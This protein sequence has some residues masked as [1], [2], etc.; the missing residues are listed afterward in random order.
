MRLDE[1]ERSSADVTERPLYQPRAVVE[2]EAA[3]KQTS[4]W[5]CRPSRLLAV[6]IAIIAITAGGALWWL[7]ARQWESTDDAFID[8]HMVRIAPQVGGRVARVLVDDNQEVAAGQLMVEI[9]PA[10]FQAKLDQATANHAAAAGSL[11]QAKAQRAAAVANAEEA[12]AEVGVAEANAANATSQ[13]KRTQPLVERQFASRQQLDNDLASARSTS[14][15]LLASQKKLAA[16]EA[17]LDVATSQ[18][19]TAKANLKSAVALEDQAQLD[20]GYT[21][22]VA[23]EAGQRRP[24]NRRRRRLRPGRAKSD[25]AGA[26]AG[27]GHGELQRDAA[28]PYAE[29]A[30]R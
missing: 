10:Y 4:P 8:V 28:R 7:Q 11:E 9:D 5:Y 13:L 16:A 21:R 27:L 25:G 12:R 3:G 23:P 17:Q 18:I 1:L 29:G 20:L 15:N 2:T 6:L 19:D 24:Q 22:V 14:S 30:D 26:A